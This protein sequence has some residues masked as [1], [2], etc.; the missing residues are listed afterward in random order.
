MMT[1]QLVVIG[2]GMAAMRALEAFFLQKEALEKALTE[3]EK[4]SQHKQEAYQITVFGE[5][6][7]ENYNRIMLSPVLA[8]ENQFNNIILNSIEWYQQHQIR[9]F[10][11]DPVI[12]INRELKTV[13]S[14]LGRHQTYDQLII[15]TGSRPSHLGFEGEDMEGITG[16]RTLADVELMKS[17]ARS[18]QYAVVVGGGLL[19]LEAAAGL[20]G[21]GMHTTVLHRS[22]FLLNRQLDQTAANLLQQ[23][24]EQRQINFL[25]NNQI[26]SAQGRYQPHGSMVS[27]TPNRV[28]RKIRDKQHISGLTLSD[29][30]QIPCDL[31]II[32]AGITPEIRIAKASGLKCERGIV[33]NDQLQ[34]SD[35]S[36]Y[37]IGECSQHRGHCY[38]LVAP[39]WEQAEVLGKHLAGLN[40]QAY[41]G[42]QSAT[43]LK[44]SGIDLFSAGEINPNADSGAEILL[45]QDPN[46]QI[47]RKLILRNNRLTGIVFYGDVSDGNWYFKLLQS[48]NDLGPIRP[49]LMFGEAINKQQ[50]EQHQL[51]SSKDNN[52]SLTTEA[53]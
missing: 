22:D 23:Q 12:S 21:H 45:L 15:A 7:H 36:I 10:T 20:A 48:G 34:T 19:G 43:R 42:T 27:P 51:L 33:V 18:G 30:Q 24:L 29:G 11:A 14:L 1:K 17:Y 13:S 2:N 44:V 40:N 28:D 53:A 6:P 5:E 37:A 3:A 52:I 50:V 9:L 47:Y 26:S 16:F 38:G 49:S 31:L 41:T 39:I 46:R 32:A 4:L 25:L 35:P 8:E